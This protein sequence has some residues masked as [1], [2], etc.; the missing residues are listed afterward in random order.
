MFWHSSSLKTYLHIVSCE[1]CVSPSRRLF[2]PPDYNTT[3]PSNMIT[4]LHKA[5]E[6]LLASGGI[7]RLSGGASPSGEHNNAPYPI[8]DYSNHTQTNRARSRHFRYVAEVVAAALLCSPVEACLVKIPS[9]RWR[10]IR[11]GR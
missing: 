3:E 10:S 2:P 7:C 5:A 4:N 1:S 8:R 6:H 11:Q 9:G